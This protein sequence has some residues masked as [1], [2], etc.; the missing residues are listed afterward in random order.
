VTVPLPSA[1]IP[2][3]PLVVE[4]GGAPPQPPVFFP[5]GWL[6]EH[7]VLPIQYRAL[8]EVARLG[9]ELGPQV[10]CMPYG[11]PPALQ[12]AMTQ[13]L[14]GTW[15][16]GLLQVPGPGQKWP[17]GVGTI[18]AVRRLLE[19]GWDRD[20]PPLLHA[21]R[22]LFRL[23]AEDDDPAWLF[24]YADQAGD[25][26]LARRGRAILREAA[27]A[28]LAQAGY[29]RDP[30]LRGAALRILDRVADYLHS[31]LAQ[32]PWVRVGNRQVLA[33]EAA[34]PS[35]HFLHMLA[36]MPLFCSEHAEVLDR[37]YDYVSQTPPRQESYQLCGEHIVEQPHLVLGD[38]LP[39][40][41]TADA[42]VPAAVAWLEL[43]A[44]LGFLRRNDH[45]AKLFER[46]LDDR[47]RDGVWH[48]HRGTE[49]PQTVNPFV[50][51]GFPL[52]PSESAEHRWTDVTFRLGLVARLT[53]R[54]IDL[55]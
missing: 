31:P 3:E 28:T 17:Q 4:P 51:A 36:H 24:E 1:A 9:E 50:W 32:K 35:I 39:S 33:G 14:D 27:A 22:V 23:L 16:D 53:G 54:Q 55:G 15:G 46:F 45:W 7:A 40:R 42:D 49:P 48:P 38:P 21:R 34:P 11:Y 44:R 5:L 18:Q 19:Y 13:R 10:A 29:E 47:G 43:A 30:R 41:T 8:T 37:V 25:E 20:S 26:D 6:L 52:D 12:L 2:A